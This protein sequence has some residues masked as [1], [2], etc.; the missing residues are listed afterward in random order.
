MSRS[1]KPCGAPNI[2]SSFLYLYKSKKKG[3][4]REMEGEGREEGLH[5]HIHTYKHH[6]APPLPSLSFQA[7]HVMLVPGPRRLCQLL[8]GALMEAALGKEEERRRI[9]A[10]HDGQ[11]GSQAARAGTQQQQQQHRHRQRRPLQLQLPL[12]PPCLTLS[13]PPPSLR[14]HRPDQTCQNNKPL[15]ASQSLRR[16]FPC[17]T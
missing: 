5:T 16:P 1:T 2:R 9:R 4:R 15:Y 17:V 13:R 3:S 6:A 14:P 10:P 7:G 12:P 8:C 11:P